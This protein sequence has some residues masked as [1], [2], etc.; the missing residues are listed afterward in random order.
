MNLHLTCSSPSTVCSQA[1]TDFLER[2]KH[3]EEIYEPISEEDESH[4]SFIKVCLKYNLNSNSTNST[5]SL[6]S[7]SQLF[8]AGE[9]YVI[10]KH[11][12]YLQSKIVYWIMNVHITPRTI[13][14]TRHGESEHNKLGK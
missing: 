1:I 2:I 12:G 13:Y 11:E 6:L 14:L 4:F 8:N 7:T 9:K 5:N 3:Y 10:H